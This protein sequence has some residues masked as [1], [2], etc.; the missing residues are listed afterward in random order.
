MIELTDKEI[1]QLFNP[2]SHWEG[3]GWIRVFDFRHGEIVF[4]PE[5]SYIYA[6]T[7]WFDEGVLGLE[8]DLYK[9][10]AV[11][12]LEPERM[13]E[14]YRSILTSPEIN[15]AC[16]LIKSDQD[17][18]LNWHVFSN[19]CR[20]GQQVTTMLSIDKQTIGPK[21]NVSVTYRHLVDIKNFTDLSLQ[22]AA[23]GLLRDWGLSH[24]EYMSVIDEISTRYSEKPSELWNNLM[25]DW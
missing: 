3:A 23:H 15:N 8:H 24:C 10:I 4:K 19:S 14:N 2:P 18:S 17:G 13:D 6:A 22:D 16:Y 11:G 9:V 21:P 7:F 20:S 12:R 5:N 1:D 25:T